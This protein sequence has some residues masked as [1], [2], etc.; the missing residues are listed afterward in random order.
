M[1]LEP[2]KTTPV[3]T[4]CIAFS[5]FI[6]GQC[7]DFTFGVWIDHS[8][9]QPKDNKPSL[10]V[11]WSRHMTSFKFLVPPKINLEWLKLKTHGL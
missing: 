10:K 8:K 9:S 5:V 2:S 1:Y 4:F 6:P 11:A 3:S 7:K